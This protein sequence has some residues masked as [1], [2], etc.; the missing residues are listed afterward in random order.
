MGVIASTLPSAL[1]REP[2]RVEAAALF[3]SSV[4]RGGGV[5]DGDG[6]PVLLIPG[7]MAGDGSMATMTRWLRENGYRTHRAGIRANVGCSEEYLTRLEARLEAASPR[8]R[9][10]AWRSSARAAAASSR[11][12]SRVRRPGPRERDRDARLTHRLAAQRAPVRARPDPRRGCAGHR[13]GARD[14]PRLAACAARVASVS[15]PTW[16]TLSRP[17]GLHR[18]VLEDRRR[19]RLAR[20]PGSRRRAGRGPRLAPRD[21]PQRRGLRRARQRAR[22][23]RARRR[24]AIGPRP[25][26]LGAWP[27]TSPPAVRA[28]ASHPAEA[29]GPAGRH[30]ATG[31]PSS[32]RARPVETIEAAERPPTPDD[33]RPAA[34][35]QIPPFGGA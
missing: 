24:S 27:D 20:L 25:P 1:A 3:R 35:R 15:A 7:F 5:P 26:R 4:W 8:R 28:P 22:T 17:S 23:L 10:S 21:G 29:Q 18:A 31:A 6:R 13:Q 30:R 16:Q 2:R 11:A 14:V 33:P 34:F 32:R 19:R 9:A 12:R